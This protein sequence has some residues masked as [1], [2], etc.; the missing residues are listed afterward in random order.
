MT[1]NKKDE[2][3]FDGTGLTTKEKN[4]G[5]KQYNAYRERYHIANISDLS[6]LSE[7][8]WREAIQV[9]Y[10]QQAEKTAKSKTTSDEGG[11][12]PTYI[13]KTL[14]ENLN[15][16]IELKK[17]LG[18]LQEE[19]GKDFYDYI[20]Q[21]KKKFKIWRDDNQGTRQ[22]VCPFC[23]KLFF[24]MIRTDK[25]EAKKPS[26]FRDRILANKHLWCLYKEGNTLRHISPPGCP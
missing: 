23:S 17:E 18:L 4:W 14:D 24:L 9:R 10:K 25:Y 12:V 15:K 19:K 26:F 3:Q 16:I 21:L 20:S 1:E 8:V 13:L 2:I 5:K 11:K 7:L 22:I 6:L